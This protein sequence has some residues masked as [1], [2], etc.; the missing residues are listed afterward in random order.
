[1]TKVIMLATALLF[2]MTAFADAAVHHHHLQRGVYGQYMTGINS[3]LSGEPQQ[4]RFNSNTYYRR[5]E[6]RGAKARLRP[7]LR[8]L[9]ARMRARVDRTCEAAGLYCAGFAGGDSEG[10]GGCLGQ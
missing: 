7:G 10:H 8:R 3:G 2:G 6:G 1:M 9:P 4:D 5:I